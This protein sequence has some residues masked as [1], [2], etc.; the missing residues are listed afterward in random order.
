MAA[1][2]HA[3]DNAPPLAAFTSG[4]RFSEPTPQPVIDAAHA[5]VARA[6]REGRMVAPKG[7]PALAPF[8][9]RS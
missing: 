4:L 1:Q 7:D 2:S 6:I 3:D 9:V 5:E 8:G